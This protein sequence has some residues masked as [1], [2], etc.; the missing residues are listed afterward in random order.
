MK[1][2]IQEGNLLDVTPGAD[3]ASGAGYLVGAGT[4]G[5]LGVAVANI[6]NGAVGAVR[7]S[8]VVELPKLSTDVV[9]VGDA[10]YWDDTNK[11]LTKTATNNSFA[12]HATVAA[13]NG[14]LVVQVLLNI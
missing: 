9:A 7:V 11:R 4:T 13:G 14:V 2:F 5:I 12:G 8:G 6:A 1:N 10:L 3:V